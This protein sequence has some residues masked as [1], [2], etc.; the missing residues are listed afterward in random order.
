VTETMPERKFYRPY[1]VARIFQISI[2]TVRRWVQQGRLKHVQIG[3]GGHIRI[4]AYVVRDMLVSAG[5]E[6]PGPKR[7][8][9]T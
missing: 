5:L 9:R 6:E 1:E 4:P 2:R 8:S 7:P 3:A